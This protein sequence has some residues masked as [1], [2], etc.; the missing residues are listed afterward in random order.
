MAGKSVKKSKKPKKYPEKTIDFSIII[1]S[2]KEPETIKKAISQILNNGLKNFEI[3]VTAPDD[4][5]LNA[6]KSLSNSSIKLVKDSGNGKPSALN[7]AVEKANGK[8]LV[9]TD[10]DVYAGDNSLNELLLPFRDE[11]IGAVTGNPVSINPRDIMLGYWA[12][13][14]TRVANK[15]R[16]KAIQLGK[17]FFCSGYLFA[18]KKELFPKL[19]EKLLSEDGFISHNVYER[20]YRIDYA[21]LAKVYVKYPSNFTDWIKQKRRS[22]GGYNQIKKMIGVEIRSFRKEASGALDLF[23]YASGVKEIFWIFLLYLARVYLWFLIYKDINL[24]RKSH[25]ELWLRIESTK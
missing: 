10:G 15:R 17:R 8:I 19:P 7:L 3:I 1:T 4:E 13:V 2:Y 24:K 5:T 20:G 6:A 12:Y 9:L 16:K 18:I 22:A 11:K 25:K 21:E 14:L 23:Q